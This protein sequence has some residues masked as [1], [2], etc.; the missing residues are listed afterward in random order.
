MGQAA[1]QGAGATSW[2]SKVKPNRSAV[3]LLIALFCAL[4]GAPALAADRTA[5]VKALIDIAAA[6]W[7]GDNQDYQDYFSEERLKTLFSAEFAAAYREASKHPAYDPPEGE[8]TGSPFDYDVVTN[9]QDGCP[10]TDIRIEDDGEGQVTAL[11]KNGTCLE[12]DPTANDDHTVIFHV[13][14]ENGHAVIDDLFQVEKGNSGPGL[15]AQML[16]IAKGE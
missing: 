9:G 11:F 10:L 3:P 8:T 15:K 7:K 2:R 4:G 12:G 14:E 6:N 1:G 5:P 16:E 13:K